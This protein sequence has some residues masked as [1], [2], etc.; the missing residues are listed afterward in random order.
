MRVSRR[1]FLSAAAT[2]GL[3]AGSARSEP[4][5]ETFMLKHSDGRETAYRIMA[6]STGGDWPVILFS[7]GANSS[8]LDYDRLW[9]VWAEGGYLVIG[10]NHIDSGP[11]ATQK[12]VGGHELW[13]A[14]LADTALPLQERAPFEALA[15]RRGG[16]PTWDAVAVA[17]HSFG[18][19]VAQALAGAKLF[20]PVDHTPVAART[21]GVLACLTFSPPGPLAG[22]IP[23]DAWANVSAPSLLQTGDADILPG[24][25][26]DW[27]IRLTGFSG[28]PDRWMIVAKG[29]DHYFGGLICRLK[30]APP[31]DVIAL[32]ETASLSVDFLDAYVR[33]RSEGLKALRDRAAAADDG[34]LTLSEV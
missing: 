23:P 8:H 26:N 28:P 30:P 19:V 32:E 12:K 6:P 10:A 3:S 13:S 34:V 1:V 11:P 29:V 24:F 21:P 2:A 7:H 27:R 15:R 17:G 16:A 5:A 25:V 14:R 20:D 22:F 4:T 31:A 33:K 18:A 9:R